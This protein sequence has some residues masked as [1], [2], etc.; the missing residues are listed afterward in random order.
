MTSRD[1]VG[2]ALTRSITRVVAGLVLALGLA[3]NYGCTRTC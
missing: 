3:T 2:G 1:M